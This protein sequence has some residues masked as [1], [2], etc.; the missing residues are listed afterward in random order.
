M[1]L[2]CPGCGRTCPVLVR[3]GLCPQSWAGR[4]RAN[5]LQT[6]SLPQLQKLPTFFPLPCTSLRSAPSHCTAL[7]FYFCHSITIPLTYD[8][9]HDPSAR[10]DRGLC[11]LF[12]LCSAYLHCPSAFETPLLSRLTSPP[13]PLA[14]ARPFHVR[15]LNKFCFATCLLSIPTFQQFHQILEHLSLFAPASQLS[16][17]IY[18][19]IHLQLRFSL[20]YAGSL[21]FDI[22]LPKPPPTLLSITFSALIL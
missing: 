6:N 9:T 1:A 12:D 17:V 3:F 19:S 20:A 22:N 14:A 18:P 7:S 11:C 21:S 2:A 10:I 15:Q 8:P 16:R 13:V 4:E 5:H